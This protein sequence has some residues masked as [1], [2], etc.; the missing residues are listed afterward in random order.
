VLALDP[1][2]VDAVWAVQ[3]TYRRDHQTPI[4][5]AATDHASPTAAASQASWSAW[6]R[7]ALGTSPPG[8][9]PQ[10]KQPCATGAPNGSRP[11]CST[12]SSKSRS[13][14]TSRSSSDWTCPRS[15]SMAACTRHP[16]VEKEPA[17]TPQTGPR[18]AGS[19]PSPPT[20]SGSRS[21]GS[22]TAPTATTASC[23]HP[24]CKPSPTAA[25]SSM[26]KLHLHRGYD[27]FLTTQRCQAL[28]LLDVVCAK[29]KRKGE[30]KIK[31]P[32]TLGLACAGPSNAPTPGYPTSAN[33]AA[34]PTGSACKVSVRSP[35]PSPSS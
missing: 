21:A 16:A 12:S 28:G 31:K 2:V 22:S 3:A 26:L 5:W 20:C 25:C 29:N 8:S 11:P 27:S 1:R 6:W 10:A 13:P 9:P 32:L 17:P 30:A 33:S 35:W 14:A 7:A 23:S 15:P 24:R 18:S 4:S 19:G 34:K